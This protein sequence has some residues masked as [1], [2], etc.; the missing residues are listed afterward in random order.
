[1]YDNNNNTMGSRPG[2][3]VPSW[4]GLPV[5]STR[6]SSSTS[7]Y[8]EDPVKTPREAI[9]L[10]TDQLYDSAKEMGVAIFMDSGLRPICVAVVGQGNEKGST[11][12]TRDIVQTALLCNASFVTLIHNHPSTNK[13]EKSLRNNLKPSREDIMLTDCISKACSLHGIEFYDSI[14]VGGFHQG[15]FGVKVP[16]FYS[17]RENNFYKLAKKNGIERDTPATNL[18]D[19]S[20]GI[21]GEQYW[22]YNGQIPGM[23]SSFLNQYN[24]LTKEREPYEVEEMEQE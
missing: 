13:D 15:I 6:L 9:A 19:I 7:I 8:S 14:I 2:P 18:K 20:W 21:N 22:S 1:M 10:V 23:T 24:F 5:V 17:M 4:K 12:S 11:I 3:L 16:V